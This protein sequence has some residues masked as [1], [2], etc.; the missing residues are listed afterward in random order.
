[1]AGAFLIADTGEEFITA[2]WH[3]DP[4]VMEAEIVSMANQFEDWSVPLQE[5]KQVMIESTRRRFQTETDPND[6]PW[7]PLSDRYESIRAR[8]GAGDGI[9][10]LTGDLE[11]AATSQEAWFVSSTA[12]FFRP[13][14]LPKNPEDGVN[15]GMAHQDGTE[16]YSKA[17]DIISEMIVK[18]SPNLTEGHKAYF[19]NFSGKGKYLPARPFIGTDEKAEEE[20]IGVFLNHINRTIEEPWDTM[21]GLE[22]LMGSN[23]HETL[24][25]IGFLPTGQPRLSSGR[26]GRKA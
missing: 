4:E 23:I 10:K 12:I 13:D 6:D 2:E 3:P 14:A 5:G 20:L 16:R 25:I 9:L 19:K 18:N 26:F 15:Y 8:L 1:M 22:T 11:A 21:G 24:P 7:Q 17:Y